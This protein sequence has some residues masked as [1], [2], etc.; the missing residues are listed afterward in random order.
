MMD[1]GQI[2][3]ERCVAAGGCWDEVA[4]QCLKECP[5]PPEPDPTIPSPELPLLPYTPPPVGPSPEQLCAE[6]GGCWDPVLADCFVCMDEEA[7]IVL[8]PPAPPEPAPEPEDDN[9]AMYVGL[10]LLLAAGLAGSYFLISRKKKKEK[11]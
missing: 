9:T 8:T 7:D 4:Q 6:A 3:P 2:T 1:P 11:P 5:P 10:G